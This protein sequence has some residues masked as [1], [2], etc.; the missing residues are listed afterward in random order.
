MRVVEASA[1]RRVHVHRGAAVPAHV[2]VARGIRLHHHVHTR[3][4]VARGERRRGLGLRLRAVRRAVGQ[5]HTAEHVHR[6]VRIRCGCVHAREGDGADGGA[7]AARRGRGDQRAQ[8][9]CLRHPRGAAAPRSG[10]ALPRAGLREGHWVR[11]QQ[12]VLRLSR[13]AVGG[14]AALAC[15]LPA[16]EGRRLVVV[17]LCGPVPRHL[18]DVEQAA[19]AEDGL[20]TSARVSVVLLV[21][22]RRR[23]AAVAAHVWVRG[24]H[25]EG[26]MRRVA[27]AAPAPALVVPVGAHPPALLSVPAGLQRRDSAQSRGGRG[28]SSERTHGEPSSAGRGSGCTAG[29]ASG[30]HWLGQNIA[31]R[32][33][34]KCGNK[35]RDRRRGAVALHA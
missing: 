25:P 13:H 33:Y 15:R 35:G 3:S 20:R 9:S 23:A 11:A 2:E 18:D 14:A 12:V 4:G 10:H 34:A 29:P 19:V 5:Q 7:Q 30:K 1:G 22:V 8:V 28:V 26:G 27:V 16:Q 21:R 6:C 31:R 17:D 24:G 32:R